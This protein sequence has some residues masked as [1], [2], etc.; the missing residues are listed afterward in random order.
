LL[1]WDHFSAKINLSF[2]KPLS[3]KISKSVSP[4]SKGM[5][6]SLV[7]VTFTQVKWVQ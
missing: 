6:K 4:N 2:F 7:L 1:S 5:F 3:L